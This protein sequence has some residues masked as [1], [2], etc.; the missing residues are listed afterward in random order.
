MK[1]EVGNKY[2]HKSDKLYSIEVLFIAD[3]GDEPIF[4]INNYGGTAIYRESEIKNKFIPHEEPKAQTLEE[5]IK[6]AYPDYDVRVCEW[7]CDDWVYSTCEKFGEDHY[8]AVSRRGFYRYVYESSEGFFLT[9][10]PIGYCQNGEEMPALP[11]ACLFE[12]EK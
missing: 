5:R 10:T 9:I 2:R 6:E 12:V 11:V 4:I 3:K 7:D 8:K 1:I